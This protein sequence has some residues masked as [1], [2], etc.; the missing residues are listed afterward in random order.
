M[1][2]TALEKFPTILSLCFFFGTF[3]LFGIL[4]L[5]RKPDNREPPYIKPRIPFIGHAVGILRYG[6]PY[7]EDLW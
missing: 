6:V 3:I 4:A 7:Y 2:F 5:E 1:S